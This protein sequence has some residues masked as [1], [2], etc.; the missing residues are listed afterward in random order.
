MLQLPE[1]LPQLLLARKKADGFINRQTGSGTRLLI[2]RLMT[3]A[4]I[5]AGMLM[6]FSHEE[7][8]HPAIAA[9]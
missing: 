8:T 3:D 4:G 2:D 5:D 9:T 6:G 7:F 1:R